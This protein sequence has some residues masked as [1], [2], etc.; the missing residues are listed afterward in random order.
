MRRL[1]RCFA[2]VSE[3]FKGGEWAV[4]KGVCWA[5]CYSSC[6]EN[7]REGVKESERVRVREQICLMGDECLCASADWPLLSSRH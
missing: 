1:V 3:D 6:V 4:R 7:E 5:L 2:A